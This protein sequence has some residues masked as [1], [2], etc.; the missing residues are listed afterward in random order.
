MSMIDV[1]IVMLNV[2]IEF[3]CNRSINQ[4]IKQSI[5]M[6]NFNHLIVRVE[7]SLLTASLKK[8]F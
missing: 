6:I 7:Q 2:K 3:L 1:A 4:S 5:V 8:F